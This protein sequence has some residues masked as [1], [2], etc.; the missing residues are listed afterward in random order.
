MDNEFHRFQSSH[1]EYRVEA[2]NIYTNIGEVR[3]GRRSQAEVDIK[4]MIV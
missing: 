1:E 3:L 2:S 4:Y